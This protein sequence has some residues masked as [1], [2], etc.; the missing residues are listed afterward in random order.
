MIEASGYQKIQFYLFCSLMFIL[1]IYYPASSWVIVLLTANFIIFGRAIKKIK[2]LR[3]NKLSILYLI[4]YFLLIIGLLNTENKV[5]AFADL[6]TK[7]SLLLAPLIIGT[8]R[9]SRQQLRYIGKLFLF[10]CL[11]SMLIFLLISV[12]NFHQNGNTD[13][14]YYHKLARWIHPSYYSVYLNFMF[15]IFVRYVVLNWNRIELRVKIMVGFLILLTAVF[16]F[17]LVARIGLL[18]LLGVMLWGILYMSIKYKK[19]KTSLAFLVI[20]SGAIMAI[21]LISDVPQRRFQVSMNEI[22]RFNA[23]GVVDSSERPFLWKAALLVIED[24]WVIGVGTGD[25]KSELLLQ[26]KKIGLE[27]AHREKLNTHNQILQTAVGNGIL[28]GVLILLLLII[29]VLK[30]VKYKNVLYIL[31]VV[32]FGA[33]M[34]FE[35]ALEVQAGIVY[36]SFVNLLFYSHCS[37]TALAMKE[38]HLGD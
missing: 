4:V 38:E 11:V 7:I 36:F 9:F 23:D 1:P 31:F 37:E 28:G 24:N 29:P 10:G 16:I 21:L 2:E 27:K 14:F 15:A 6:E 22:A 26:Y 20:I 3:F 8:V 30:A 5:N 12:Y 17:M 25:I 19:W 33:F 35:S 34:L 13:E 32:S 18:L